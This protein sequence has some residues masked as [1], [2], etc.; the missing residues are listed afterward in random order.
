MASGV[1][2]TH[3]ADMTQ[4][5]TCKSVAPGSRR[6]VPIVT[7]LTA[8]AE[9]AYS[10]CGGGDLDKSE[11][12]RRSDAGFDNKRQINKIVPMRHRFFPHLSEALDPY[13]SACR[14]IRVLGGCIPE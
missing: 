8:A 4:N 3:G 7:M 13:P 10:F 5:W 6:R 14:V 1:F 2:C 9:S 12:V 11:L